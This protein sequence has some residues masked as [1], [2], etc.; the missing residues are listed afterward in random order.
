MEKAKFHHTASRKGYIGGDEPK[1]TYYE[2][3]F[4]KGYIISYPNKFGL[5]NGRKSNNYYKIE[6]YIY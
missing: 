1:T 6:Y 3:K 5:K 4:G 2:G